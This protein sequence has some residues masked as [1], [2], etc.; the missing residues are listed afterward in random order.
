MGALRRGKAGRRP[1]NPSLCSPPPPILSCTACRLPPEVFHYHAATDPILRPCSPRPLG[2]GRGPPHRAHPRRAARRRAPGRARAGRWPRAS[3]SPPGA[4]PPAHP[5]PRPTDG[6]RRILDDAHARLAAAADRGVDVGPAGEWLLDNLPRV[7]EHIREVRESLPRGYYRELP[8][9]AA[10]SL[11]GYPRVYELAITL[12]SHTEGRIDLENVSGFV[13]AFQEV[14]PLTHR[15]AVG[16]AGDAPARPDRER[17]ADGAA[18]RAA[19]RRGR[20]GRRAR[21]RQL[22]HRERRGPRRARRRARRASS[23]DPP[24]LTPIFVSRFLQQLRRRGRRA[25]RRSSGS[26]SGSPRRR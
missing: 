26:S 24:P 16:G 13:G 10:G 5:A 21:P 11:A 23:A 1:P 17:P 14:A 9:L 3:G 4:R 22:A 12:I 19:A 7:Q 8:E 25:S 18:H 20:G 6:T 15:R 2:R